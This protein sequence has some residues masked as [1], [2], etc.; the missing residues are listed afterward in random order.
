MFPCPTTP[1]SPL[2]PASLR[3]N[4]VDL[5]GSERILKSVVTDSVQLKE[6]TVINKSLAT[7]GHVIAALVAQSKGKTA[8][9]HYRDSKLTFLLRNSIGG[10]S[11]TF[12][13]ATVSPSADNFGETLSTLRFAARAQKIVNTALVNEDM[14]GTVDALRQRLASMKSELDAA[15]RKIAEL[16]AGGGGGGTAVQSSEDILNAELR[17]ADGFDETAALRRETRRATARAERAEVRVLRAVATPTL[18]PPPP[19]PPARPSSTSSSRPRT[20]RPR[21]AGL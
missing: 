15:R 13:V 20:T 3:S 18:T 17:L 16:R 2:P 4:L 5:A 19:P 21:A 10:N 12:L 7:L 6:L 8:H 1:L 9:V 11:K 14:S